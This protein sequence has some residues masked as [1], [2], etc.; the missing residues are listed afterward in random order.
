MRESVFTGLPITES[1][2]ERNCGVWVGDTQTGDIVGMLRFEGAVQ[3][4][5]DVSVLTGIRWPT[6]LHRGETTANSFVLTQQD[7]QK[8][9]TRG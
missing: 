5:F 1:A 8:V 7:L 9:G 2:T 6:L 3:E 4:I